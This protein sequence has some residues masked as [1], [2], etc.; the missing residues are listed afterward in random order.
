MVSRIF[1]EFCNHFQILLWKHFVTS[2]RNLVHISSKFPF[3]FL[4]CPQPQATMNLLC[5]SV[6]LS[7]LDNW[8]KWNH[9]IWGLLWL[10]SFPS[11]NVF[12]L[13]PCCS[14][15]HYFIPFVMPNNIPWLGHTTFYVPVH[16]LMDNITMYFISKS[17]V[18]WSLWSKLNTCLAAGMSS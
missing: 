10:A 3:P 16:Q 2:K 14:I 8:Y 13:C 11:D 18:P 17:K 9:T 5:V 1:T 15:Y 12:E 4:P 6:D 7:F